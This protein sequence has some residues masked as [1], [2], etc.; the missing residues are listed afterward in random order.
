MQFQVD[1]T[2][3]TSAGTTTAAVAAALKTAYQADQPA[4]IVPQL[5][6]NGLTLPTGLRLVARPSG[7]GVTTPTAVGTTTV[8]T[9]S[10]NYTNLADTQKT[11]T[12]VGGT[13]AVTM[14]M[15]PRR[16]SRSSTPP[17]AG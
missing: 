17:G 7:N 10:N 13:S 15:Q 8:S 1:S 9:T 11:F 5:A 6:Y 4:P 16:S 3:G 2:V 14:G 12:P